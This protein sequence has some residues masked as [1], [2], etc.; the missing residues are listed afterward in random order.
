[1]STVA[2][3]QVG[4]KNETVYGTP[5]TVDRFFEFVDEGVT[6]DVGRIESKSQRSGSRAQRSDRFA[7][8]RKGGGGPFTIQPLSKGFGWWLVHMLGTVATTGPNADGKFTHTGTF[9]SLLGDFFTWQA[10]RPLNPTGANQAFTYHGGKVAK[11]ELA[12]TIEGLLEVK[13]DLDFEDEDNSTGLAVASYP[14][15]MEH[16]SFVGASVTIGGSAFDATDAKVVC[17]NKLKTNRRYLRGSSLKKEPIEAALRE[18]S[19][20]LEGD[21]DALT[22]YNRYVSATAAG[23]VAQVILTWQA[24]TLIA[25]TSF[26][27]LVVTLPA[28]RFDKPGPTV[29]SDAAPLMQKLGG[30]VLYDGTNSP[31]TIA[32]GSVDTTP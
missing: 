23:A 26:P 17:D 18:V 24:P 30:K 7:V 4:V 21:F 13:F 16:F 1:V 15:A 2:A 22:Q 20:E 12:N 14:T 19:F 11:W 8:D 32:Y 9:G 28:A 10:N 27:T 31:V 25:G 29:S 3:T 5:V 6:L